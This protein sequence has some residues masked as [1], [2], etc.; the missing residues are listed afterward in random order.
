MQEQAW[1]LQQLQEQ[2]APVANH[3][4]YTN[5]SAPQPHHLTL[6]RM[7]PLLR[8]S[9]AQGSPSFTCGM[10]ASH[11]RPSCA[12]LAKAELR[13]TPRA[14]AA[15]DKDYKDS[16]QLFTVLGVSGVAGQDI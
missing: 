6:C 16:K 12:S 9:G 11:Q 8:G 5:T 14:K 3:C 13:G 10:Q 2:L 15:A 1:L 4:C 7:Q